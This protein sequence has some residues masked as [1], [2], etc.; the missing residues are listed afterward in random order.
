MS[1]LPIRIRM[2][3]MAVESFL[4]CNMTEPSLG[5]T[6]STANGFVDS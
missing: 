6:K 1:H 5:Y 2:V 3:E 4:K